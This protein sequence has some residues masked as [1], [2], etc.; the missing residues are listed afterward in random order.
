MK[1]KCI[2]L[3]IMFGLL[4]L[5]TNQ[6]ASA[7]PQIASVSGTVE[8]NGSI[9]IGG[10][11]FGTRTA[12]GPLVFDN[13]DGGMNGANI[14]GAP[15]T[16]RNISPSWV[17]R[18]YRSGSNLPQYSNNVLRPN[19]K[20]SSRHAFGGSS[21]NVS[22]EIL[23][24]AANSGD[25][26]YFSFWRYH[27]KTSATWSRN[28]KPWVVY[29]SSSDGVNPSTYN[30]WGNPDAA[31]GEFRNNVMDSGLPSNTLWGGPSISSI[32]GEWVR[33]EGYLRQSTPSAANGAFQVWVHRTGTPGIS[34]VQSDSTYQTRAT[35]NHWRQWHFGSYHAT[36]NPASATSDVYID[37]L[38]FD[39]SP[40]RVELGDAP[41]WS[42]CTRRELQVA[43]SWTADRIQVSINPGRFASGQTAYLYVIDPTGVPN[44]QGYPVTIG[45][46][47]AKPNPPRDVVAE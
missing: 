35:T 22:L 40:A 39:R 43:S 47:Q 29:G 30:G 32:E 3:A 18:T 1:H 31:D 13:F 15:P 33:I 11:A 21:Y 6:A 23:W 7:A 41:Q 37:D 16:V 38:Y 10:S 20:L 14:G 19:S 42:Q 4:S 2:P 24:D 8:V 25:E 27:R 34:L 44:T 45:E 5:M 9:S 26:I 12:L 36:D 17:W 46:S 28:V